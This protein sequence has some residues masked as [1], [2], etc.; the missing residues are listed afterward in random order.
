ML[1]QILITDFEV[2]SLYCAVILT[3]C[4]V[5]AFEHC[6]VELIRQMLRV[7]YIIQGKHFTRA[8]LRLVWPFDGIVQTRIHKRLI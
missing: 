7:V 5:T 3:S 8:V 6:G 2:W 1:K 4:L